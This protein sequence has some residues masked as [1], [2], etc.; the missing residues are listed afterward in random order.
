[1]G[2]FK[3]EPTELEIYLKEVYE[4]EV[5]NE[6]AYLIEDFEEVPIDKLTSIDVVELNEFPIEEEAEDGDNI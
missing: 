3:L 5:D 4:T 6:S 1:M 2:L